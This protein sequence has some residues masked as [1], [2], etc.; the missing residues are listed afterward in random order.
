MLMK[1]RERW[2]CT[3]PACGCQVVVE[4]SGKVE[5][6]PPRCACGEIMEKKYTSPVSAYLDF[7]RVEEPV[8]VRTALREIDHA[9]NQYKCIPQQG[10]RSGSGSARRSIENVGGLALLLVVAL[11]VL[12]AYLIE[13]QFTNP[14]ASQSPGVFAAAVLLSNVVRVDSTT[15]EI[16][17]KRSPRRQ[18]VHRLRPR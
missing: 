9:R 4:I 6:L 5:G 3:N 18:C 2:H 14:L 11:L 13:D 17:R 7:L 10:A 12:G 1:A 8:G 15:E 16:L